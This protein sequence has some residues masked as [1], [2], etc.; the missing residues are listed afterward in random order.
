MVDPRAGLPGW[1]NPAAPVAVPA[2]A[3]TAAEQVT[4]GPCAAA[5]AEVERRVAEAERLSQ[6]ATA[7]QQRL[8]ETKRRLAELTR[9]RE[10]DGQVRDRHVLGETKE[11]LRQA[12]RQGYDAAQDPTAVRDAAATWLREIDR[13]NRQAMLADQRADDIVGQVAAFERALPNV[14]LAADAARIAA[15]AAQVASIDARRHLAACEEEA[16]REMAAALARPAA[17]ATSSSVAPPP[18]WPT[19]PAATP[20]PMPATS[21][22]ESTVGVARASAAAPPARPAPTVAPISLLLRGDRQALLGLT[23]RLA[24]ETGVEA[25]RLQLLLLELREAIAARALEEH[26]LSFP[27]NHPFWS[28]FTPDGGRRV[29]AS[30]AGLGYACDGRGGW[31]D[32]RSPQTRALALAL[33]YCGYDPRSLRRPAG[34]AAIDGL[35]EGTTVLV[36]DYLASGAPDLALGRL[37]EVLGERGSR[38]GELW[39]IWGRLRPLL[40]GGQ[41]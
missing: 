35:W 5:R 34:Q 9:L 30:L 36:E 27:A 3:A 1:P 11:A 15:E 21:Q 37:I 22:P 16:Q 32:G 8:R 6:A 12:Y 20:S 29:A 23:L 39:D 4:T 17:I 19:T 25:G 31:V 26:A 18:P 24:E 14:E 2:R 33:S 40:L 41:V 38:L 10:V 13:L 7:H 28:Q